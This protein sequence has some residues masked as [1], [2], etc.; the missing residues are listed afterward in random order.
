MLFVLFKKAVSL[1]V[2]PF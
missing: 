1:R 2:Q